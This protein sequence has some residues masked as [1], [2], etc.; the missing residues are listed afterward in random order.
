MLWDATN[1]TVGTAV[2]NRELHNEISDSVA[3]ALPS[4]RSISR[5]AKSVRD[6]NIKADDRLK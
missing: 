1:V 6:A 3:C 2:T 4:V 5:Y